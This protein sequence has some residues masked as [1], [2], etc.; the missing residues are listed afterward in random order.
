MRG[1]H[2][3]PYNLD[4]FKAAFGNHV[5]LGK[6]SLS[7][8]TSIFMRLFMGRRVVIGPILWMGRQSCT[9]KKV[10]NYEEGESNTLRFSS[11]LFPFCLHFSFQIK[12]QEDNPEIEIGILCS[13]VRL[14]CASEDN[15]LSCKQVYNTKLCQVGAL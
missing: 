13:V 11:N 4:S 7:F 2:E 6:I 5:S 8:H 12:Q 10:S 15:V 3:N 9:R 14:R 1:S